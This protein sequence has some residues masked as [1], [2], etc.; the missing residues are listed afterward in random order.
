MLAFRKADLVLGHGSQG[1]DGWLLAGMG[2][3][4]GGRI[5]A[6]ESSGAAM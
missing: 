6:G 3:G 4:L 5:L 1:G 2:G